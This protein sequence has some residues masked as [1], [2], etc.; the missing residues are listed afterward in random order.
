MKELVRSDPTVTVDFLLNKLRSIFE[1]VK[2][3]ISTIYNFLIQVCKFS[4]KKLSKWA[5][6]RDLSELK[7]QKFQWALEIKDK[8][9]LEKN[10]VFIDEAGFNISMRRKYGWS[11][12]GEKAV[13]EV[14]VNATV[15]ETN[16]K[17]WNHCRTFL[18]IRK[19]LVLKEIETNNALE[20]LKV[21]DS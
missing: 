13:L 1:D 14:S 6:R 7:Q 18:C 5:M 3:N 16:A 8:I 2:A 10:Y 12:V 17:S 4:L 9:D 15:S 21:F 20:E 19:S 11:E